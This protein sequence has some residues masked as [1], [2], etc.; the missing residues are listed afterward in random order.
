MVNYDEMSCQEL[1][2]YQVSL[3]EKLKA[4]LSAE[5]YDAVLELAAVSEAI[6]EF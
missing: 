3:F 6:G 2:D 1:L 4:S 5:D